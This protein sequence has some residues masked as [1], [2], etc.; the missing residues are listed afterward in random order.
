M[1]IETL[2]QANDMFD[3]VQHAFDYARRDFMKNMDALI[4]AKKDIPDS[5][6]VSFE[7]KL[8]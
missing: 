2:E 8:K 7:I 4:E 6:K 5:I 1:K 3:K